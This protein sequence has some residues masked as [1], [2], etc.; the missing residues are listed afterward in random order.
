MTENLEKNLVARAFFYRFLA[1]MFHEPGEVQLTMLA[2]SDE[3]QRLKEAAEALDSET[4]ESHIGPALDQLQGVTQ[5]NT[6][7][8]RDLRVEYNRLFLGPTR[9]LCHPYE[10]VYDMDREEADQGTVMGPSASFFQNALAVE[11]LEIDLGRAELYDHVAIELEFMYFLLSKA[12]EGEGEV[13]TE[14]QAKA[15]SVLKQHL[16]KWLPAFGELVAEKSSHPLYQ[17]LGQLLTAFMQDE[18]RFVA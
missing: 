6:W 5:G 18:A 8:G 1:L 17:K 12:I 14:Y 3:F 9:P 16:V 2:D 15:K 7:T 10:S 11:N 13:K 4:P